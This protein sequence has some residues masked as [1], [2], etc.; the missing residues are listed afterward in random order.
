MKRAGERASQRHLKP[1]E[2]PG[3][4]ERDDDAQ[5]ERA[6]R[7]PVEPGRHA[8]LDGLRVAARLLSVAHLHPPTQ[9]STRERES[10]SR[11]HCVACNMSLFGRKAPNPWRLNT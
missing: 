11:D 8:R 7:Q 5:M 1:I 10:G 2:N 4:A 6:E 3:D 9:I